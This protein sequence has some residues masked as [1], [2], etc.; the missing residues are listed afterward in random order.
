MK[1]RKEKEKKS[2]NKSVK[3]HFYYST[4]NYDD[5]CMEN[6]REVF[7]IILFFL[8]F[9]ANVKLMSAFYSLTVFRL[10]VGDI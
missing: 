6:F 4:Q 10:E 8:F 5:S 7:L 2:C 1:K 3:L 9:F